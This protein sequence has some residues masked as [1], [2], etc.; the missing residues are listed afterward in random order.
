MRGLNTFISDIRNC[1]NKESEQ[2]RCEKELAKIRNKFTSN[3]G[4]SGYHKKKYV[5]KLLY[6]HIL[7][8]EIDFGQYEAANLINSNKFSEKY[9]GYVATSE[10]SLFNTY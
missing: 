3:K 4:L 9:T 10:C 6:M 8:Y 1:P 5:W 7:G 2:R